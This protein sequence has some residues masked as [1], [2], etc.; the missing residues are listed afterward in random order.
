M[1]IVGAMSDTW[2]AGK[3][4]ASWVR[5]WAASSSRP[6]QGNHNGTSGSRNDIRGTVRHSGAFATFPVDLLPVGV[7]QTQELSLQFLL[8]SL[9]LF[10]HVGLIRAHGQGQPVSVLLKGGGIKK[11]WWIS[12]LLPV[13][14]WCCPLTQT[15]RRRQIILTFAS[16]LLH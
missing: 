5:F 1:G 2:S 11:W 10:L 3:Q 7:W 12:V 16:S 15:L 8:F 4:D 6:L 9:H 13:T 14:C